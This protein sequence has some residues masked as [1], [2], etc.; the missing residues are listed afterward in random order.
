MVR[1]RF[2]MKNMIRRVATNGFIRQTVLSLRRLAVV[3][4][5]S[6]LSVALNVAFTALTKRTKLFDS[7]QTGNWTACWPCCEVWSSS[8]AGNF[9]THGRFLCLLGLNMTP[10]FRF[11]L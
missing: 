7:R 9:R 2:G 4:L 8:Y 3:I 5:Q 1:R 10:M 11:D 6:S